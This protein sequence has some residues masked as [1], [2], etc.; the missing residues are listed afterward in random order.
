[1]RR[2]RGGKEREGR[3]GVMEHRVAPGGKDIDR[4][5]RQEEPEHVAASPQKNVL[6]LKK[7]PTRPS[8]ER[9]NTIVCP[10]CVL[11]EDRN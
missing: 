10:S 9:L 4:V 11:P 5:R 8:E 3:G 7:K 2:S 6:C 1:M